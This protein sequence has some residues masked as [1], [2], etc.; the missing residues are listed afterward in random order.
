MHEFQYMRNEPTF[1]PTFEPY[2]QHIYIYIYIY[3]YILKN[4]NVFELFVTIMGLKEL[5]S[6]LLPRVIDLY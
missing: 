2:T 6:L 1:E 5:R 3:I 4:K